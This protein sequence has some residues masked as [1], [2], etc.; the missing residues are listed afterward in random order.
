LIVCAGFVS[1]GTRLL[2]T[3]VDYHMGIPAMHRSWPHWDRFWHPDDFTHRYPFTQPQWILIDRDPGYAI[4]SAVK[5]GHPGLPDTTL[6]HAPKSEIEEW[7]LEW[8]KMQSAFQDPY[9][10]SYGELVAYPRETIDRLASYLSVK[11]P[12]DSYPVITDQNEKWRNPA[13]S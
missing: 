9:W 11:T 6:L 12:L 10:I 13:Q 1:S 5:A 7:W 3:I 2:H 4:E 8:R